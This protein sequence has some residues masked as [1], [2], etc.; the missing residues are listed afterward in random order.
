MIFKLAIHKIKT[1]ENAMDFL[2]Y[3]YIYLYILF[4]F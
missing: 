3:L 1:Y 4:I 2:F